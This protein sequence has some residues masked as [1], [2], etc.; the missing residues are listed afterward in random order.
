MNDLYIKFDFDPSCDNNEMEFKRLD[1][2][3]INGENDSSHLLNDIDKISPDLFTIHR[4]SLYS[5]NDHNYTN[6]NYDFIWRRKL[7]AEKNIM[8]FE[9]I[10]HV[11]NTY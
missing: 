7:I 3:S 11:G 9:I 5:K 1:E 8:I 4:N 10:R 6:V 2:I